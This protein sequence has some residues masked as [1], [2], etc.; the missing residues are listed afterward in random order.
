[1][2]SNEFGL[3]DLDKSIFKMSDASETHICSNTSI[4]GRVCE[5][6]SGT[7]LFILQSH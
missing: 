7:L 4:S 2:L 3:F 6:K 5:K 1:M